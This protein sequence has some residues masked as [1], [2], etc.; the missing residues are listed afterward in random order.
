M[1]AAQLGGGNRP[2]TAAARVRIP[3]G[4]F[5]PAQP[6]GFGLVERVR[7]AGRAADAR[8]V[9]TPVHTSGTGPEGHLVARARAR[10]RDAGGRVPAG[11]NRGVSAFSSQPRLRARQ[12]RGARGRADQIVAPFLRLHV[13]QRTLRSQPSN[14]VQLR[15]S[16]LQSQVVLSFWAVRPPL[17]LGPGSQ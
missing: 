12:E 13:S 8:A 15:C 7:C 4:P 14:S 10:H 1:F 16:G 2:L 5:R 11:G 17:S 9:H 6:S 3:Y